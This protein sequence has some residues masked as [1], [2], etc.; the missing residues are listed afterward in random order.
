MKLVRSKSIKALSIVLL[1]SAPAAHSMETAKSWMS[2]AKGLFSS[3]VTS[4]QGKWAERPSMQEAKETIVAG[5]KSALESAQANVST[6]KEVVVNGAQVAAKNAKEY[7]QAGLESAKAHPYIA[8]GVAATAV[9]ATG[10]GMYKSV[11]HKNL[12]KKIETSIKN[13]LRVMQSVMNICEGDEQKT[14]GLCQLA[15]DLPAL[16]NQLPSSQKALQAALRNYGAAVTVWDNSSEYSQEKL[17]AVYSAVHK[18]IGLGL[19]LEQSKQTKSSALISGK[20]VKNAAIVTAALATVP[21]VAYLYTNGYFDTAIQAGAKAFNTVKNIDFAGFATK[22]KQAVIT[23]ACDFIAKRPVTSGFA[24]AAS[25]GVV[26]G[27]NYETIKQDAQN[28][29]RQEI[30]EQ[31]IAQAGK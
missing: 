1:L 30:L 28:N 3:A 26:A 12:I 16:I 19:N 7:A 29:K 23:P 15:Q 5:T 14:P 8:A 11:A 24:G 13:D 10:Y 4:A 17:D 9:A 31:Q 2:S 18:L 25:L 21:A 6:A 22:A 20:A 27:A